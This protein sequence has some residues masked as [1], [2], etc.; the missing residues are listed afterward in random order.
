MTVTDGTRKVSDNEPGRAA[1]P[2]K[3]HLA[4]GESHSS[5]RFDLDDWLE[6]AYEDRFASDIDE[7][8]NF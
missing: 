5:D 4:S 8:S 2:A 1:I 7:G 6:S 3:D